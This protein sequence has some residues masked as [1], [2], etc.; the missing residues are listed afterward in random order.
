M[1]IFETL[2]AFQETAALK[3]AIELGI[4]TAIAEGA[5]DAAAIAAKCDASERG[6]RILC[7]IL[8][9]NGLLVKQNGQ[10][11]NSLNAR[12]FLDRSSPAYMGG[13]TEFI[14]DQ[15]I[16]ENILRDLT[17]C[18]RKAGSS[19]FATLP[20]MASPDSFDTNRSSPSHR[21]SG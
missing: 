8:M 5:R 9:A 20:R 6:V 17:A 2:R 11:D 16:T 15:N 4:F 7:D 14:C 10:Y 1:P 3:S 19:A 21:R 12:V 13:I 18:V